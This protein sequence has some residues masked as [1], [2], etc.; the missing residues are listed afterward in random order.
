MK[1]AIING[2][3]MAKQM[4]DM[5]ADSSGDGL[6]SLLSDLRMKCLMA[7]IESATSKSKS[8]QHN[9]LRRQIARISTELRMRE[10]QN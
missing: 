4:F 6:L 10:L 8:S 7:R 3:I 9:M 5:L 1:A 2:V